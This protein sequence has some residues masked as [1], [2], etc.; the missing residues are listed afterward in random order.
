MIAEKNEGSAKSLSGNKNELN[1]MLSDNEA[2][3]CKTEYGYKVI[4]LVPDVK[5]I[6]IEVT[7]RCNFDCTTCIRNGWEEELGHMDPGVF[8]LLLEQIKQLPELQA[9]HFGGFGEPLSHPDIFDMI[10]DIKKM[11]VKV[12]MI[13]NG[14]L[15]T[16]QRAEKLIESG[17]DTLFVSLDGPD[18]KLYN[19]IRQGADFKS[20]I[21]N[22]EAFNKMK[23]VRSTPG[24]ELG[25]EFVL[26]KSNAHKLPEM[27]RLVDKLKARWL[28]VT[29]VLPYSEELKDEIVYDIDETQFPALKSGL[30]ALRARMPNMK[31]RTDRYCSFVNNKALT[32]TRDGNVAPCYALMHRYKCFIYGKEKQIF[33]YHLGNINESTLKEIWIR[34]EYALFRVKVGEF[35]FPSCTDCK[36]VDGCGYIPDNESDCW[37]N[38]PSCGECL[39]ARRMILCP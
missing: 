33:P 9:V 28:I 6:Y 30:V 27:A 23:Q 13:T 25:I 22:I 3:V 4:S 17:L 32:V 12:E 7:T 16:E 35:N 36:L 1:R 34:P 8:K 38:S 20:V 11:D 21:K 10:D 24:P 2:L 26:M 18:E 37:G 39:W 5:K 14:S 15:L 19:D 29:N 31:L